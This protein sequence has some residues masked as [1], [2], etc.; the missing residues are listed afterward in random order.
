[1]TKMFENAIKAVRPEEK[2]HSIVPSAYDMSGGDFCDLIKM[3]MSGNEAKAIDL[4]FMFG[5]VMG[6]RC[7]I[8]R[9]MKRL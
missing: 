2:Q 9:D 3:A 7:T 8:R 4:A 6:N 1:M 5:F